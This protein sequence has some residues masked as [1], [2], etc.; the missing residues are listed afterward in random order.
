MTTKNQSDSDLELQI[1]PD[2]LSAC[3]DPEQIAALECTMTKLLKHGRNSFEKKS[4]LQGDMALTGELSGNESICIK[5][6]LKRPYYP[7]LSTNV[8]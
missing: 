2:H 6:C 3:K 7:I 4:E 5:V 1:L 8:F